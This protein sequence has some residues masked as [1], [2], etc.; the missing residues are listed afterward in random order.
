ML[1]ADFTDLGLQNTGLQCFN[2]AVHPNSQERLLKLN[3]TIKKTFSVTS[4]VVELAYVR[5]STRPRKYSNSASFRQ[6]WFRFASLPTVCCSTAV[7][8]YNS[9]SLQQRRQRQTG[10]QFRL[11]VELLHRYPTPLKTDSKTP[12]Y[13]TV[14][15]RGLTAITSPIT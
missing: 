15:V 10:Q 11:F 3:K 9:E 6:R 8:L 13:R 1:M 14:R 4:I 7:L 5:V 12:K 2:N